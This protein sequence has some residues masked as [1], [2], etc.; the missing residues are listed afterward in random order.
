MSALLGSDENIPPVLYITT[1]TLCALMIKHFIYLL[2][3]FRERPITGIF[4]DFS[5]AVSSSKPKS[6]EI[7]FRILVLFLITTHIQILN[8]LAVNNSELLF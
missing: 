4:L 3:L 2:D 6:P 1:F 7:L 5:K 8:V